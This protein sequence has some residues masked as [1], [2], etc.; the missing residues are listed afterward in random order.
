MY[1][2]PRTVSRHLHFYFTSK[3][4]KCTKLFVVVYKLVIHVSMNFYHSKSVY[5]VSLLEDPP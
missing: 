1:L 2:L 5:Q 3:V 4:Y